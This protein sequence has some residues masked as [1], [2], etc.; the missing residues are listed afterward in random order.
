MLITRSAVA[1]GQT[2]RGAIAVWLLLSL[3][4]I[5]GVVA[6]NLD[7]GRLM[8]ERR[9][10]QAA[11]DAAALAAAKDLYSN[12]KTNHGLDIGGTARAAAI[13]IAAANGYPA[14]AV[15]VNIPPLT[16]TFVGKAGYV[17]VSIRS[18]LDASFG[19]IFTSSTLPATARSVAAGNPMKLG[20]I[21]LRSSGAD[22]FLN[23]SLALAVLNA[24]I[25]INSSD[26]AA[27]RQ[28]SFGAVVATRMDITGGYVNPGNA[29]MLANIRTGST[30]VSDPLYLLPVPSTSGMTVRSSSPLTVNTILPVVLQPGVYQGG[31]RIT[32]LS[33]VVM[34]PGVYVMNGGGFRVDSLATVTGSEVMIYNTSGTY[35]AGPI[36]VTGKLILS[37]PLSGTYQGINFFQNRSQTTAISFTGTGVTVITGTIYAPKAPVSLT[38]GLL[39]ALDVLGGA[40]VVDSMTVDGLGSVNIDLGLNPP[41]VPDV[42]LVE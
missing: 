20:I 30:P 17:E 33:T 4:V 11:A 24:P 6:I 42:R 34:N 37:A 14:S 22:A 41:L 40:Y 19:K 1:A 2:R 31:I 28:Q 16:G 35:A 27:Y 7:G 13:Q 26:A 18:N 8:D 38:G 32:G 12:T 23:K 29:I 15:T 10:A 21:L 9:R 3:T 39:A 36:T 5:V 25:I